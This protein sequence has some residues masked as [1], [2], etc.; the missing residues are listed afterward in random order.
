MLKDTV[1]TIERRGV[2]YILGNDGQPVRHKPWLGDAFSFA[3]DFLMKRLIFPRKLQADMDM[4]RSILSQELDGTHSKRTL[5]LSTGSGDSLNYLHSDNRYTGTDI[6]TGLLARA[7]KRLRAAGFTDAELY[8][9]G[10]DQ[11]PFAPSTFDMCLCIL[12]LNFYPDLPAV[13][14]EVHRVLV[15]GGT[16]LCCVPVPERSDGESTIRGTLRSAEELSAAFA[17]AGFSY[18]P[19]PVDN[20]ALLYFRAA[21]AAA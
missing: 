4:H 16:M 1:R 12:S 19:L 5:E 8:C 2:R 21:K 13:L 3:Y 7:A 14:Q 15:P 17:T 20:G 10:V 11:L 9:T 6:S 18:E